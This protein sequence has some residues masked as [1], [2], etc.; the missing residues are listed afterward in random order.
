MRPDALQAMGTLPASDE[1]GLV[2]HTKLVVIDRDEVFA[3]SLNFDPRSVKLN[4]EV[5]VF[6]DSHQFG[7]FMHDEIQKQVRNFTYR[8]LLT[9]KGALRWHYDNPK[10]SSVTGQEPGSTLFKR[11]IIGLTG[12]MGVVLQL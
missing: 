11:A 1:R 10:A 4:T 2:M 7:G 3:G 5:G 12:L 8:L 9:E 6:V